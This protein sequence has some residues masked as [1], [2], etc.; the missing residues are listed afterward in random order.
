[1]SEVQIKIKSP[2][3]NYQDVELCCE[4][5]EN[6]LSV[7]QKI[8]E[9]FPTKPAVSGQ[10]LVY[11][12]K[13]LKDWDKLED[14]LRFDDEVTTYTFHLVCSLPQKVTESNQE[15]ETELRQ[16]HTANSRTQATFS[17][18]PSSSFSQSSSSTGQLG[19]TDEMA[20]MMREFSTQ[21]S[22]AMASMVN[23]PSE[24]EMAAMQQMYNQYVALYMQYMQSQS[25]QQAPLFVPQVQPDQQVAGAGVEL[26]PQVAGDGV[27]AGNEAPNPGGL[28]MNAGAAAGQIQDGGDRQRDILDWVYVMTRVMLLFSVI[29]FHS[30]F[31]RLAFVA[32]LGFLAYFYQNRIRQPAQNLQQQQQQQ[33][34]QQEG[35]HQAQ[36]PAPT[37]EENENEVV[38][39]EEEEV[40]P[41]KFAVLVTF[42]TSLISSI[43][44]EQP[45]V[46]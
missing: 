6:V 7:K 46:I 26:Q 34:Q 17:P 19:E 18:S 22:A 12:G 10:K 1:M 43:I 39:E 42:F 11:S 36:Q 30:S 2:S 37:E 24:A 28:V 9:N 5:A 8:E 31:F 15:P 20:E 33:Q 40:P 13:I 27:P 44:P 3:A 23:N 45:Q 25:L 41:S 35:D 32:G 4:L 16:R 38:V 29:Y 21:Y 14:V